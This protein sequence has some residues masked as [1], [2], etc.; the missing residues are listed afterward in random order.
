MILFYNSIDKNKEFKLAWEPIQEFTEEKIEEI[1]QENHDLIGHPGIQKTYDRIRERCK[2][3]N[4]MEKI[5]ERI[6]TCETCQTAKMTRIRPKEEPCITDTPLEPNDK[7]AMDILG[8]LK[9]TK[10]GNS[11]ILS[12]HDELTKYLI[13]V[14]I[15]N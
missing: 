6:K 4:L 11:F 2:I 5:Q 12:I 15:R 9:K 1:L 10:Q 7:I 14:P 3:L 8:P 13:L